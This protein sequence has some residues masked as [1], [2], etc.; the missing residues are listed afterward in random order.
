M[1]IRE[2]HCRNERPRD[3]QRF[4]IIERNLCDHEAECAKYAKHQSPPSL[5]SKV[6][7]RNFA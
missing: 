4:L 7:L 1:S 6:R 5:Q 3:L 2:K